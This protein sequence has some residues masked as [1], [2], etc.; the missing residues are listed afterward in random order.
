M[1][2]IAGLSQD[3]S[4]ALRQ[5]GRRPAARLRELECREVVMSQRLRVVLGPPERFDPLGGTPMLLGAIRPR[6]L[7]I[8]DVSNEEMKKGVLRLV[9]DGRCAGALHEPLA[10]ERV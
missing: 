7:P 1:C 8:C 4:R 10:S 5:L 9:G 2:T 3:Q 6:D